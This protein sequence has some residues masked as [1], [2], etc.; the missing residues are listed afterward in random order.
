MIIPDPSWELLFEGTWADIYI[1]PVADGAE[2]IV[3]KVLRELDAASR[4]AFAREHRVLNAGHP[5]VVRILGGDPNGPRPYYFMPYFAGGTLTERAGALAHGLLRSVARWLAETFA[6]MHATEM[7]HGDIKPDNVLITKRGT[8]QVSDPLGNGSGCTISWGTKCGG[9]PGY[10][11]PEIASGASIS[12]AGDVFSL[13]ATIFHL[14]TGIRPE[15]GIVLDPTAHAVTLPHDLQHAI[16]AMCRPDPAR[17][18]TMQQVA[19]YLAPPPP[20]TVAVP[21]PPPAPARPTASSSSELPGWL[22]A[23]GWG[24]ALATGAA[25]VNGTTKTWNTRS[26][27]Y[28]GTDGRFRGNGLFD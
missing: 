22:K 3:A 2:P 18:P 23:F 11:A 1:V 28:H 26:A 8:P 9:T 21:Q 24:L 13:G 16:V 6:A 19:A 14:A 10:M 27:R 4:R 15:V 12:K 7:E 5:G 25:I 17:R 20:A